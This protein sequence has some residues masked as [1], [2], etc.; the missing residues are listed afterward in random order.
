M[1]QKNVCHFYNTPAGCRRGPGCNFLH[2]APSTGTNTP[3]GSSNPRPLNG[4]APNGVCRFFWNSG[5]CRF[6]D[7][8]YAHVRQG[9]AA[10]S[11]TP[12]TTPAPPHPS[13]APHSNSTA[14]TAPLKAASA[15]YQLNKI[16]LLPNFKFAN[17]ATINRFVN[18]LASCSLANEWVRLF[19]W[20]DSRID[21]E[22]SPYILQDQGGL[23]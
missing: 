4:N 18:I 21:R 12:A 23:E 22:C 6:T 2:G 15:R 5:N 1:S 14:L 8:R 11:P 16:F 3:N 9:D 7:C 13:T 20:S 17:P 19:R 10:S